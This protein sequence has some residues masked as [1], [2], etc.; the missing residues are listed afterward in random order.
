MSVDLAFVQVTPKTAF[1]NPLTYPGTGGEALAEFVKGVWTAFPDFHLELLNCGEIEPEL[2]AIHWSLRGTNTAQRIEGP[3]TGRS[4]SIKGASIIRLAGDKIVSDLCYFDRAAF[5][6]QL[7]A[8][9]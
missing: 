6:K 3:P 2:V 5:D 4:V 8:E 7:E 1:C 9:R